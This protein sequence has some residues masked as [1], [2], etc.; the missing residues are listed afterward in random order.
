MSTPASSNNPIRIAVLN[1]HIPFMQALERYLEH[2][3]DLEVVSKG[4][5][6]PRTLDAVVQ[7]QP[8]VVIIDPETHAFEADGIIQRL[9][10]ALPQLRIIVLTMN[11]DERFRDAALAAGAHDFI[12]KIDA[13]EQLV[14][15]IRRAR[16]N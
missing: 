7:T 6:S 9:Y 3:S 16:P 4:H 12:L 10:S 2:E 11:D 1:D 13:S 14:P 15:A 8:D 5:A